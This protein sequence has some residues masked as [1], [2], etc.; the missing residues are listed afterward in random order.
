MNYTSALKKVKKK[1]IQHTIT[2]NTLSRTRN[3]TDLWVTNRVYA[4]VHLCVR[5][6]K[7]NLREVCV[8][9]SSSH[10]SEPGKKTSISVSSLCIKRL[11][12]NI[13]H[14]ACWWCEVLSRRNETHT[15]SDTHP[16]DD[17][18][19]SARELRNYLFSGCAKRNL[20]FCHA[21]R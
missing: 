10:E 1:T 7:K 19:T 8:F 2:D 18:A 21:I 9:F 11:A 3:V 13:F 15:H 16:W 4:F 12:T 5:K 20:E 6:R 14:F 17:P